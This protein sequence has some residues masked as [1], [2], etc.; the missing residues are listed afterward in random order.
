[1][2]L[3][4]KFKNV[5]LVTL[6]KIYRLFTINN[7]YLSYLII[8]SLLLILYLIIILKTIDVNV[9]QSYTPTSTRSFIQL[10]HNNSLSFNYTTTITIHRVTNSIQMKTTP[11]NYHHRRHPH[12]IQRLQRQHH[13]DQHYI[14]QKIKSKKNEL[15]RNRKLKHRLHST[16]NKTKLKQY[17]TIKTQKIFPS[18]HL[19][20]S[21]CLKLSNYFIGNRNVI[22]T[23]FY[24]LPKLNHALKPINITQW[25]KIAPNICQSIKTNLLIVTFTPTI[26]NLT[27]YQI[28]QTWGSIKY[29]LSEIINEQYINGLNIIE[30]LFIVNISKAYLKQTTKKLHD[31][32]VEAQNEKDILPL[33]L[34]NQQQYDF[35]YLYILTSE[36]LLHYCKHSIDFILFIHYDLF[37]NLNALIQYTNSK[38]THL[39]LINQLKQN[40]KPTIYCL[41]IIQKYNEQYNLLKTLF[42]NKFTTL[43]KQTLLKSIEYCDI[44]RS[45][46]LLTFNT[47]KQWYTCSH[48]YAPFNP[49]ELYLTGLI[50]YVANIEIESYWTNYWTIG[51]LLPS[52]GINK[53]NKKYLLFQHSIHQNSR[54]WKSVFRAI[55]S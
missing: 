44:K 25:L 8:F 1:M 50:R 52:I 21:F 30:H 19:N 29:V 42:K 34:T 37:P 33:F 5:T 31:F 23:K 18:L 20:N 16:K 53:K 28:R 6:N 40:N 27:R 22:S 26:N 15:F 32:Y 13:Q 38:L 48:I 4:K 10:K 45:G 2:K 41:P 46:Y 47:L 3:F 14:Q 43:N 24:Q 17:T 54:V 39:T 7:K 35:G 36:F 9:T 51:T 49:I 11:S 12:H 55:L